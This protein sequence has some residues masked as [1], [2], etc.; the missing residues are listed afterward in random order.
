M[1]MKSKGSEVEGEYGPSYFFIRLDTAEPL[2][3]CLDKHD[4]T[5]IH[6]YIHF[7][8]DI[9]LAYCI[10]SN[11]EEVNRLARVAQVAYIKGVERPFDEWGDELSCMSLQSANTWGGGKFIDKGSRILRFETTRH[12][13]AST[14]AR[15]FKHVAVLESGETY[16]VGARDMLEY[17]AHK[18]EAKHWETNQPDFPYRT[19]DYVFDYMGLSDISDASRIALVEFC[20][21]NDN[22]FHHFLVSVKDMKDGKL[23]VVAAEALGDFEKLRNVLPRI[24]WNAKG[25]FRDTMSTKVQRRLRDLQN[26]L[27]EKFHQHNFADI[28][29]WVESVIDYVAATLQGRLVFSELFNMEG[30]DF[31]SAIEG[32]IA[33]IGIPLIFNSKEECITLLPEGYNQNQFIQFYVAY[34]FMSEF[35]VC[36][37]NTCPLCMFCENSDESVMTEDCVSNALARAEG[38]Q[39]CP[40]GQFIKTYQLQRIY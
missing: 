26:A 6:E 7:I 3:E 31:F 16:H 20:L 10:R 21:H 22:P 13:I 12:V 17:I 4:Q 34:K 5:F 14:Q 35:I 24:Q 30:E 33:E 39:L 40:F 2:A 27:G 1:R 28:A 15:V 36:T 23:N 18:I 32:M 38:Q 8:Q 29:R 9:F 25:G 11:L 19:M 37:E